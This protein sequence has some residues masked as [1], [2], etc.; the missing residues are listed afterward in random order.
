MVERAGEWNLN[1]M[2]V[3]GDVATF[4]KTASAIFER[5]TA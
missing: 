1:R 2:R 3:A 5:V 4:M